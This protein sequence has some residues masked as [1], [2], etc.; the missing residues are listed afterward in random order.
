VSRKLPV[1]N[2]HV[3]FK[4][5]ADRFADPEGV[6]KSTMLCECIMKGHQAIPQPAKPQRLFRDDDVSA[7][8]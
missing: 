2:Q 6:A 4:R 7:I 1:F 5:Q 8:D 3:L